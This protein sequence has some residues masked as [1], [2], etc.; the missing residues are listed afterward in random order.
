MVRGELRCR[1]A[2]E[3]VPADPPLAHLGKRFAHLIGRVDAE[4]CEVEGHLHGHGQVAARGQVAHERGVGGVLDL[5]ARVEHQARLGRR[6]AERYVMRALGH[7][8]L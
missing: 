2:A 7:R 1:Y 4:E 8:E 6:V 5:R 3:R